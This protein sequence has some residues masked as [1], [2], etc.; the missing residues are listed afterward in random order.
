MRSGQVMLRSEQSSSGEDRSGQMKS[1]LDRTTL[2]RVRSSHIWSG[3][4][5][6]M[7]GQVGLD[8][9]TSCHQRYRLGMSYQ[10]REG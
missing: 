8:Q 7:M 1:G 4:E 6:V 3:K 9:G 5:E 10:I 2:G